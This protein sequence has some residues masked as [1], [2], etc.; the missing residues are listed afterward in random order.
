MGGGFLSSFLTRLLSGA[1]QV[2]KDI[3]K[4][5]HLEQTQQINVKTLG[6][7][8]T[9]L[10]RIENPLGQ[11]KFA[12]GSG[13]K[14]LSNTK[15]RV[16]EL[17]AE[18]VT[19]P[20]GTTVRV[21]K[22]TNTTLPA[23]SEVRTLAQSRQM[24]AIRAIGR[25]ESSF[26]R[27]EAYSEYFNAPS[28]NANVRKYGQRGADYGF[29][30]MNELDVREGIRLGMD[31]ALARHLHGGGKGGT[32]SVEEQ[33][34]A[35]LEYTK[36]RFPK[37]FQHLAE[38]GDFESFRKSAVGHKWF[39]L[40]R[41]KGKEAK[42]EYSRALTAF[43]PAHEEESRYARGDAHGEMDRDVIDKALTDVGF[44]KPKDNSL[45]V[46]IDFEGLHERK[47]DPGLRPV[48]INGPRP[49]AVPSTLQQK[50]AWG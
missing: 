5:L 11:K 38:T 6:D 32:S 10:L 34:A 13:G 28:R 21:R 31:P 36:L 33:S 15:A 44:R 50:Y 3:Q 20:D 39:G 17:E 46:D 4:E 25:S 47:G 49:M 26:S 23:G 22:P 37:Q 18:D 24:A 43:K 8:R 45:D 42:A 48:S 19:L 16:A 41:D 7:I 27:K 2:G 1:A 9:T 14:I 35:V 40:G 30:Q 29:F 12:M